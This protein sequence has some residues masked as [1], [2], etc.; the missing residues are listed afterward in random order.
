MLL[1]VQ[2]NKMSPDAIWQIMCD[3]DACVC[4]VNIGWKNC[5]IQTIMEL[6]LFFHFL[7]RFLD[8]SS[9]SSSVCVASSLLCVRKAD[10]LNHFE[11]R[12]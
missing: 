7:S 8:E 4:K 10:L 1:K 12:T 3:G 2:K 6:A 5:R 9:T 11:Q